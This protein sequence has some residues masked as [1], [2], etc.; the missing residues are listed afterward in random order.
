MLNF[1]D[2][3]VN[4]YIVPFFYY[5]SLRAAHPFFHVHECFHC[6]LH[7]VSLASRDDFFQPFVIIFSQIRYFVGHNNNK[8]TTRDMK[9]WDKIV[10][11]EDDLREKR[12]DRIKF[13]LWY[14]GMGLLAALSATSYWWIWIVL[15]LFIQCR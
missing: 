5:S 11:V 10:S 13:W 6:I 3:T 4:R 15:G 1:V 14:A 7:T 9:K 2:Y 12:K 8:T